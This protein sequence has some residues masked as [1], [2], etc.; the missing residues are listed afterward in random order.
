MRVIVHKTCV[1]RVYNWS[2]KVSFLQL[3]IKCQLRTSSKSHRTYYIFICWIQTNA[4]IVLIGSVKPDWNIRNCLP[5]LVYPLTSVPH[6]TNILSRG[7]PEIRYNYR[8]INYNY[9]VWQA[10]INSR[11][12]CITSI[13]KSMYIYMFGCTWLYRLSDLKLLK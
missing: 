3:T 13:L 9:R 12:F 4:Y 2:I 6:A 7:V 1:T 5:F 10:F 8:N 11:S